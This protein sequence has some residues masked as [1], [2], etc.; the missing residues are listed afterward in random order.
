MVGPDG[1][2]RFRDHGLRIVN[3]VFCPSASGIAGGLTAYT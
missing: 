1:G 3:N 2:L